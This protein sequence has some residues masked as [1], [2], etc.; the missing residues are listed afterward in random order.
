MVILNDTVTVPSQK[1]QKQTKK[2]SFKFIWTLERDED[3]GRSAPASSGMWL[4][5]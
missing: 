5:S 3:Q 1:K 2:T 4:S